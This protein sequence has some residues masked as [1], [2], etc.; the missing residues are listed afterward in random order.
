MLSKLTKQMLSKLPTRKTPW[1]PEKNPC[2]QMGCICEILRGTKQVLL[3][4]KV[5]HVALPCGEKWNPC[6]I[7]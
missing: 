1:A 3:H 6:K 5:A 7:F 4:Y 2:E